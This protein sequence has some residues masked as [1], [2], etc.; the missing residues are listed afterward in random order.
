MHSQ[1]H[2]KPCEPDPLLHS[3]VPDDKDIFGQRA[4]RNTNGKWRDGHSE[5]K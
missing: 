3:V 4:R 1:I 2:E 5:S